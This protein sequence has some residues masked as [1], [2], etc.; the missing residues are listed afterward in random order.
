MGTETVAAPPPADVL[1]CAQTLGALLNRLPK[2]DGT[3]QLLATRA[4]AALLPTVADV[5]ASPSDRLAAVDGV[6]WAVKG[7]LMA[8]W[9]KAPTP[10]AM[11][12]LLRLINDR[13]GGA[14]AVRAAEGMRTIVASDGPCLTTA[15]GATVRQ[16]YKQ[17]VATMVLP[18]VT[19]NTLPKDITPA[20]L[21]AV[22]GVAAGLPPSVLLS[23]VASTLPVVL[24]AVGASD[25]HVRVSALGTLRVFVRS[26][27][28][29]VTPHLA[30]VVP[31][32]LELTHFPGRAAVR[33]EAV[34]CLRA[35]TA[36][37]FAK[38]SPWRSKVVRGLV[39]A[40]D[41]GKRA[42][43]RRAVACRNEWITLTSAP[44]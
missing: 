43:R 35:F 26:A 41:D 28:H 39:A 20:G 42:V 34:D 6:V 27:V 19:R 12:T 21:L 36:L 22:C 32:L 33:A 16:L 11:S 9:F 13:A 24:V 4:C 1:V 40:L 18:A 17:R 10:D 29:V 8:G 31:Q 25:E 37:P 44:F 30:S 2:S 23:E 14:V 15:C 7:L 3:L 38:L 5:C